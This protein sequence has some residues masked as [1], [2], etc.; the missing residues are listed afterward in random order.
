M[1]A[2]GDDE[3][4]STQPILYLSL[5]KLTQYANDSTLSGAEKAEELRNM[6][7]SVYE[8]CRMYL[9]DLDGLLQARKE[10]AAEDDPDRMRIVQF[11]LMVDVNRAGM[12]PNFVR[13]RPY[14]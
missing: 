12:L 5:Q 7:L 8:L 13:L 2:R 14:L 6:T 11:I 3:T 4:I 1:S 10:P 9:R